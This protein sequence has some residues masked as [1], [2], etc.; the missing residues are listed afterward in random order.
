M[1]AGAEWRLIVAATARR[2]LA[3]L[4]ER[5]AAAVIEAFLAIR[6]NPHRAGKPLRFELD[7]LWSARRGPYRVLYRIDEGERLVEIA[8]VA[9]RAHAYRPR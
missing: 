2:Q 4:P 3:V 8:S 6:E 9:H 1:T 7:G 5:A